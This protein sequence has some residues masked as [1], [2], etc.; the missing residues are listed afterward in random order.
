MFPRHR[1]DKDRLRD[2]WFFEP[3]W[4][5]YYYYDCV[6]V[7]STGPAEVVVAFFAGTTELSWLLFPCL[8]SILFGRKT[9]SVDVDRDGPQS[10]QKE[11][12][13]PSRMPIVASSSLS[14]S[15]FPPLT[16]DDDDDDD[17]VLLV[18]MFLMHR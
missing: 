17:I 8:F 11:R 15:G 13:R 7:S 18:F 14:S 5:R 6:P 4:H 2:G 9:R 1:I 3:W 12:H 10:E 16:G